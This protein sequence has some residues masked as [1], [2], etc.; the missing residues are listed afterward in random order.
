VARRRGG[1]HAGFRVG[2]Y[3]ALAC[4]C[5]LAFAG[6]V[7]LSTA[8]PWLFPSLGP[9]LMTA[10]ESPEQPSAR[11]Q[12]SFVGHLVGIFIGYAC[13]RGF[14]L[15]NRPSAPVGGLTARYVL[16]AAISVAATSFVLMILGLPHP[17]AGASTLIVSLGILTT[18]TEILT[19]I[20]AVALMTGCVWA[21][22]ALRAGHRPT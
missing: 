17:P 4:F 2:S 7:G 22:G 11:P 1:R 15:L 10:F 3:S 20:L 9:T 8:Q 16:A 19:M 5:L 21:I 14:D 18:R 6:W 13:L 12:N